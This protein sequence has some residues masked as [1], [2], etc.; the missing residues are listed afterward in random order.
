MFTFFTFL[1]LSLRAGMKVL[2][3]E[4]RPGQGVSVNDFCILTWGLDCDL[5]AHYK[6]SL[7]LS[8]PALPSPPP[9]DAAHPGH[10][11]QISPRFSFKFN[12]RPQLRLS[13]RGRGQTQARKQALDENYEN[14]TLLLMKSHIRL[15]ASW[16]IISSDFHGKDETLQTASRFLR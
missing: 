16:I 9:P 13:C 15:H 2:P 14:L 4:S 6:L 8:P 12:S 7:T 11:S 3:S 1:I 10:G 5:T